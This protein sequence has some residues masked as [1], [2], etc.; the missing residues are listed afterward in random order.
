MGAHPGEVRE[1]P[2]MCRTSTTQIPLP[3]EGGIPVRGRPA[4]G[5][6]VR[7][8]DKEWAGRGG[9]MPGMRPTMGGPG[10]QPSQPKGSGTMGVLMP[11]YTIGIVIFFLYTTM[12]VAVLIND[13]L[14]RSCVQ[15]MFKNKNVEEEEEEDQTS[16]QRGDTNKY[17]EEYYNNYIKQYQTMHNK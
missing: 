1:H 15:I 11:I 14:Y 5:S 17:D 6:P 9:P 16:G 3:G 8:I 10:V 7:T 13:D 4:P 2:P 12:K